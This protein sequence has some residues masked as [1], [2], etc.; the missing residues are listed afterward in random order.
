VIRFSVLSLYLLFVLTGCKSVS[1]KA[2]DAVPSNFDD[3]KNIVKGNWE[4]SVSVLSKNFTETLRINIENNGVKVFEKNS[5][6]LVWEEMSPGNFKMLPSKTAS[7]IHMTHLGV[8][9]DGLW[10][11]TWIL[12]LHQ[13]SKS[14][15]EVEWIRTVKNFELPE[16]NP[17]SS[18]SYSGMGIFKQY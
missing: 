10:S 16:S 14:E 4:G 8:D 13:K 12:I 15:L 2:F 11:E 5:V 9:G 6:T 3:R 7:V 18:F 17:D 1:E